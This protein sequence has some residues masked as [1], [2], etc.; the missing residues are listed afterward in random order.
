MVVTADKGVL[1]Y[2]ANKQAPDLSPANPQYAVARAQL[3]SLT[4]RLGAS[5]FINELVSAEL[6]RTEPKVNYRGSLRHSRRTAAQSVTAHPQ[7]RPLAPF[8]L[9]SGR[10]SP[11]IIPPTMNLR[12]L[13]R[14]RASYAR[15]DPA[16]IFGNFLSPG[17]FSPTF[18]PC[19]PSLR[20]AEPGPPPD[21]PVQTDRPR[22][23]AGLTAVAQESAPA[24]GPVLTLEE[25]VARA[26]KQ[27]F[28][29][30]IQAYDTANAKESLT[31]SRRDSTPPSRLHQQVRLPGRR[32]RD[33]ARRHAQ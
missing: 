27:N 19:Q 10:R 17:V 2:A 14:P 21:V 22:R 24:G 9:G 6:K 33:H 26:L 15:T 18:N 3:S 5:T 29:L 31:I 13:L 7:P 8:G 16:G 25:C 11:D 20:H 32:G 12:N 1:V 30:Q 4:A 28:D 23:R